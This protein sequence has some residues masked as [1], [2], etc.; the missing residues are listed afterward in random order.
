MMD[1]VIEYFAPWDIFSR[2]YNYSVVWNFYFAEL[3]EIAALL[4]KRCRSILQN[5]Q[6][7]LLV[8]STTHC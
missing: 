4:Q 1:S 8:E 3:V 2:L 7:L 6:R 5:H